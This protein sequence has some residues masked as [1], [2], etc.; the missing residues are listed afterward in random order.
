MPESTN[1]A[2]P[3]GSSQAAP[4]NRQAT[5]RRTSAG[6]GVPD[7]GGVRPR[8]SLALAYLAERPGRAA[9]AERAAHRS[10]AGRARR[11]GTGRG[12]P[13]RDRAAAARDRLACAPRGTGC[14]PLRCPTWKTR[15]SPPPDYTSCSPCRTAARPSWSPAIGPRRRPGSCTGSAAALPLHSTGVGLGAARDAPPRLSGPGGSSASDLYAASRRTSSARP[16]NSGY[17]WPKIRRDGVAA[18]AA[19]TWPEPVSRRWP[20]RSAAG[21]GPPSPPCPW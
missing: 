10:E 12:R 19:R 14:E 8:R 15:N 21:R 20:R 6:P 13:L 16:G 7:H 2:I 1:T 11:P 18:V 17:S 5:S 4:R 3:D 9:G